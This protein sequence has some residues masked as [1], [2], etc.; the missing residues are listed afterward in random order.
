MT[1]TPGSLLASSYLQRCLCALLQRQEVLGE[2]GQQ[3][4]EEAPIKV[5]S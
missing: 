5:P 2:P 4:D 1:G 3:Q